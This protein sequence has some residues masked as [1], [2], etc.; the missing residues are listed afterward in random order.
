MD[1]EDDG[2]ALN[3]PTEPEDME[4]QVTARTSL[5][6]E[7]PVVAWRVRDANKLFSSPT[8]V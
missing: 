7:L 5:L 6:T 1:P 3:Q 4:V 2:T 8:R